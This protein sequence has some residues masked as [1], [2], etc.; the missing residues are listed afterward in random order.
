MLLIKK[1]LLKKYKNDKCL[2][3]IIDFLRKLLKCAKSNQ[4]SEIMVYLAMGIYN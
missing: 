4:F 1:Y 2:K 3:I